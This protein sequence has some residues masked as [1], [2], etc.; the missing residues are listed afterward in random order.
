MNDNPFYTKNGCLVRDSQPWEINEFGFNN[1]AMGDFGFH[2]AEESV[3][4]NTTTYLDICGL[5]LYKRMRWPAW[6]GYGKEKHIA[7]TWLGFK[8]SHLKWKI[9]GWTY[10]EGE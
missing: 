10:D 2:N 6:M 3:K 9:A 4:L 8:L 7:K 1:L 5:M